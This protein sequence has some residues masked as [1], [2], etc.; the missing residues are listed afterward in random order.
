MGQDPVPPSPHPHPFVSCSKLLPP[1]SPHPPQRAMGSATPTPALQMLQFCPLL[2]LSGSLAQPLGTLCTQGM[3]S[4][5]SCWQ[6]IQWGCIP[7]PGTAADAQQELE[8]ITAGG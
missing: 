5:P 3:V 1:S 4:H 2:S 8:N 7:S 6:H